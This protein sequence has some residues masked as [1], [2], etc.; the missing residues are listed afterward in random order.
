MA[1]GRASICSDIST[2]REWVTHNKD[3]LLVNPNKPDELEN[4]LALLSKDN[5]LRL[6]LGNNAKRLANQYDEDS[7]FPKLLVYYENCLKNINNN[8]RHRDL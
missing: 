2:F 6:E 7:V 3:V 5:R 8:S 4:A 1:S